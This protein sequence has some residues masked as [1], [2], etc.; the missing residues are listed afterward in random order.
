M[1]NTKDK[2]RQTVTITVINN[3]KSPLIHVQ[4]IHLD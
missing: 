1:E 4:S 3:T 2:L